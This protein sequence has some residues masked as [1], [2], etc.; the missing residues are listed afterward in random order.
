MESYLFSFQM[1]YKSKKLTLMTGFVLQGHI[2][3][4][5]LHWKGLVTSR[6]ISAKSLTIYFQIMMHDGKHKAW[7]ST[8]EQY[9]RCVGLVNKNASVGEYLDKAR[10]ARLAHA[11]CLTY[12]MPAEK[13]T[14]GKKRPSMLKFSNMPCTG[15][16]LILKEMLGAFRS[17]QQLT[18]SS[19]ANRCCFTDA[20]VLGTRPASH[21]THISMGSVLMHITSQKHQRRQA[22]KAMK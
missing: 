13:L 17:M 21:T 11:L 6:E 12:L 4:F 5:N 19:D 10:D 16:P 22:H 1:M 18:T 3:I 14:T 15:C 2:L 8:P 20:T 7:N 9:S